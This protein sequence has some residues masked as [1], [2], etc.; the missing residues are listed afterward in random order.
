MDITT[1]MDMTIITT[2]TTMTIMDMTTMATII[3]LKKQMLTTDLFRQ[4]QINA[5][6][7]LMVCEEVRMQ[8]L[9]LITFIVTTTTFLCTSKFVLFNCL[10]IL[11]SFLRT[12]TAILLTRNITFMMS[13]MATSW[14]TILLNPKGRETTHGCC[15][16]LAALHSVISL[17]PTSSLTAE[18][19][20]KFFTTKD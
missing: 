6:W 7:C 10:V 5:Q 8:P 20:A 12:H 16:L 18:R 19:L 11:I 15:S 13:P 4:T 1:T 3:T 17:T 14:A 2:M 9:N